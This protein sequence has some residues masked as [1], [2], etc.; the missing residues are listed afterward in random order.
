MTLFDE[1]TE[2][3]APREPL[4]RVRMTVAYRGDGF[5]GFVVNRGVRTVAGVLGE[6][7]D[8]VLGH[9][10]EMTCAGRTDRGVHSNGQ[11]VTFNVS[12]E[13]FSP[14]ALQASIN[15]LCA[16]EIAVRDIAIVPD[17]FDAR[18]SAFR[19]DYRYT[20]LNDQVPDPFLIDTTWRVSEPLDVRA[21][22]QAADVFIGEHNFASFCRRQ[23]PERSLVRRVT[24][25]RWI[26]LEDP[27]LLRFD[28]SGNAFCQQMVRSIVGT[29]VDVGLGKLRAGDMLGIIRAQNRSAAPPIAPPTGLC[30]WHVAYPD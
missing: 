13:G 12:G 17:T 1:I 28:I 16:P 7:F 3:A 20:I 25:A 23:K 4:V 14:N 26:E 2:P 22:R 18:G 15:K 8:R 10:V 11:V 5:H 27:R 21:M 30:L 9:D 24:E 19:R 29:L 6:A